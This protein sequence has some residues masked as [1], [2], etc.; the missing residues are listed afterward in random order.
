M[1]LEVS[2]VK[3]YRDNKVRESLQIQAVLRMYQML[4]N[5]AVV[6]NWQSPSEETILI[7]VEAHNLE[8]FV[9]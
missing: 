6:A 9:V 3:D 7:T 4:A 2:R 8:T 1:S 5:M